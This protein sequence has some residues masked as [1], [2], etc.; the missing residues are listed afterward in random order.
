[1][2]GERRDLDEDQ[3]RLLSRFDGASA[4]EVAER[5]GCSL[6]ELAE[7]LVAIRSALGVDSTAAAVQAVRARG[8]I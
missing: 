5:L 3:V 6:S 7:R 1:M 4:A 2:S 8:L